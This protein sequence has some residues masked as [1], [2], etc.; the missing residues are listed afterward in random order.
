MTENTNKKAASSECENDP[1][2]REFAVKYYEIML[3]A[4]GSRERQVIQMFAYVGP[5]LAAMA[6]IVTTENPLLLLGGSYILAVILACG[7]QH[8]IRMA[9]NFRSCMLQAGKIEEE[10]GWKR[11]VLKKWTERTKKSTEDILPEMFKSQVRILRFSMW[12]VVVIGAAAILKATGTTLYSVLFEKASWPES[13]CYQLEH[14]LAGLASIGLVILGRRMDSMCSA[15]LAKSKTDLRKMYE[16]E[17]KNNDDA[18]L[19]TAGDRSHDSNVPPNVPRDIP[20]ETKS[21]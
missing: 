10:T 6:W 11:F 9:Y 16:L 12:A 3:G 19:G 13:K 5:A 17:K 20:D 21:G 15:T 8:I 2:D 4:L 14:I 7:R 1:H 18:P